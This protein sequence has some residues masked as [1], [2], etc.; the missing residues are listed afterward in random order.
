MADRGYESF[1]TF[2]HFLRK[3]MKFVIRMILHNFCDLAAAHAVVK[4]G[5]NTKHVY[6]INFATTIN[7]CRA[8]LKHGGDETETML[9]IQRH[10]MPVRYNRKFSSFSRRMLQN[11]RNSFLAGFSICESLN[12]IT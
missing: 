2:A 7:I 5:K 6:K 8:Y 4:T 12:C 3:G 1:N 11:F 9:L 10:L